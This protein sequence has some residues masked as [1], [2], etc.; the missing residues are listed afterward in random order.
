VGGASINLLF[1]DFFTLSA[2]YHFG[3]KFLENKYGK[4]LIQEHYLQFMRDSHKAA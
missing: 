4:E 3:V 1:T 2:K